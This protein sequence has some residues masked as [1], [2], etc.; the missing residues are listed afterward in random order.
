MGFGATQTLVN[1]FLASL[2]QK[3]IPSP[4]KPPKPPSLGDG[5]KGGG[6]KPRA[7]TDETGVGGG[8]PSM[9]EGAAALLLPQLAASV[10]RLEAALG[11][12]PLARPPAA[13][14][15]LDAAAAG[16]GA[17]A[18]GGLAAIAQYLSLGLMP[19]I[20]ALTAAVRAAAPR[21]EASEAALVGGG[22]GAAPRG[23]SPTLPIARA[24]MNESLRLLQAAL[25]T[26][27][28]TPASLGRT[29]TGPDG[30]TAAADQPPLPRTFGGDG[31]DDDG[32]QRAP[33]RFAVYLGAT[34]DYG[35]AVRSPH[36]APISL[37]IARSSLWVLRGGR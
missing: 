26:L 4:P 22:G 33:E 31:G 2:T 9:P 23:L 13:A 36:S 21:A 1:A 14:A 8:G 11:V 27:A 30:A 6:A 19:N 20:R 5:D 34:V 29:F 18:A 7:A 37:G 32:A 10:G 15:A 28:Q 12:E 3:A 35:R 24:E 17:A 25:A 16:D